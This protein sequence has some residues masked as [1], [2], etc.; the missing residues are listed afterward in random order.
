MQ[1]ELNSPKK[2]VPVVTPTLRFIAYCTSVTVT[3][4]SIA[5]TS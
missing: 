4:F 2:K 3:L 5:P 1:G